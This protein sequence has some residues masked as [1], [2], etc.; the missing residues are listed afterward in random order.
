MAKIQQNVID[1]VIRPAMTALLPL[2]MLLPGATLSPS[3]PPA[4]SV[5]VGAGRTPIGSV[6]VGTIGITSRIQATTG[7]VAFLVNPW[8]ILWLVIE[9]EK[10]T[11]EMKQEIPF[12]I[13]LVFS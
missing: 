12:W 2:D 13:I 6:P 9:T 8:C 4:T 3:V 7:L 1:S 11:Q 10:K 5:E